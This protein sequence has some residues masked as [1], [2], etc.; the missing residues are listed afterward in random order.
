MTTKTIEMP[1]VMRCEAAECAYNTENA[2][3]ALAITIGDGTF[4]G[5]DTFLGSASSSPDA[6]RIAGVGACKVTGCK[7]NR[8]L[9]CQADAVVVA[10]GTP[11]PACQTFAS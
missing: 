8:G 9:D 11:V 5:C 7:H 6:S 4:P 1:D 2:C 3:R 10:H